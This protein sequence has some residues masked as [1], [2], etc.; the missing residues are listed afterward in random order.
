MVGQDL[1]KELLFSSNSTSAPHSSVVM[2]A[3]IG[4]FEIIVQCD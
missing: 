4:P 2:A 1:V 3:A